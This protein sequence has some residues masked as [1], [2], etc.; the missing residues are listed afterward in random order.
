M[1]CAYVGTGLPALK[2][3]SRYLYRGVIQEQQIVAVDRAAG[4]V[5][6]RYQ[7]GK[8]K[9]SAYRTL[10][11]VEF[12][13]LLLRHVL[14]EGYRRVR[15]FGVLHSDPECLPILLRWV[16]KV[17]IRA[18]TVPAPRPFLCQHSHVPVRVIGMT[19][20]Q[21]TSHRS[22]GPACQSCCVTANNLAVGITAQEKLH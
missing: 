9:Q 8:T 7:D 17:V 12:V 13:V 22:R 5:T 10:A 15:D 3:F 6:F 2:C 20:V 16:L 14:P 19:R 21:P 1:H 4:T 18:A 11:L